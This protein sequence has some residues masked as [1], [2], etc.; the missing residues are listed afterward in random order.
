MR[1][2]SL[3]DLDMSG[4]GVRTLVSEELHAGKYELTFNAS[5]PASGVYCYELKTKEFIS[6]RR[7]LLL[8]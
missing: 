1:F 8:R 5:S 6:T 4:C 2:V 7:L 3:K